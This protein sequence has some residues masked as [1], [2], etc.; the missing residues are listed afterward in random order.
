MRTILADKQMPP[1]ILDELN[2]VAEANNM[3]ARV[4][5]ILKGELL[6]FLPT[7]FAAPWLEAGQLRALIP[8]AI[9]IKN[10]VYLISRPEREKTLVGQ[11]FLKC[12]N[13]VIRD[14]IQDK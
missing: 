4:G 7:D 5:M 11:A 6:G 10:K 12:Y 8:E 14:N 3:H 13:E 9:H 2:V 1:G